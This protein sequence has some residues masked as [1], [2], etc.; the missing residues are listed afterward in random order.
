MTCRYNQRCS[1]CV[2]LIRAREHAP[3]RETQ[4]EILSPTTRLVKRH[5]PGCVH[6]LTQFVH[7]QPLQFQFAQFTTTPQFFSISWHDNGSKY[8]FCTSSGG[9]SRT[10]TSYSALN[11]NLDALFNHE[12]P[13]FLRTGRIRRLSTT[14][15][16]VGFAEL[17]HTRRLK[18]AGPQGNGA[19]GPRGRRA[20]GPQGRRATA[21][22]TRER[23]LNRQLQF[24]SK[25]FKPV[26]PTF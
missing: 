9:I 17:R 22:H 19:A 14:F 26:L 20:A 21:D 15:T 7:K 1:V 18:A 23:R 13:D 6:T 2:Q 5:A 11:S 16:Q 25:L 8:G 24:L 4:G 10:C 3:A 12:S